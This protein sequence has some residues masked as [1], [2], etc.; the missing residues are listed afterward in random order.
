M[1]FLRLKPLKEELAGPG[2]T[3]KERFKYLLAFFIVFTL[4][5]TLGYNEPDF[6]TFLVSFAM[7][8]L[9]VIGMLYAWSKNG[10]NGGRSFLD[11]YL[12]LAWVVN[13]RVSIIVQVVIVLARSALAMIG[14]IDLEDWDDGKGLTTLL[15]IAGEI[16]IAW[17]VGY[18]VGQVR[19]SAEA[20]LA[21]AP[22]V[23]PEQSIERLDKLVE[24]I[25]HREVE[26][27]VRGSRPRKTRTP[28]K[29]KAARRK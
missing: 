3:E 26:T 9:L 19:E 17:N 22:A 28:K 7:L 25:V 27:A 10:K 11:R 12:S 4:A 24:S 8:A 20:R 29:R 1:Y 16:Y 2:L 23:S 5:A 6:H 21:S 15:L 14:L 13:L 18:H